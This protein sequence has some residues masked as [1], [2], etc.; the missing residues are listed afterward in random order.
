MQSENTS[1]KR[2][3]WGEKPYYSLD[4]HYRE[5]F[6]QKVYKIALDASMT[7][8][9]RDGTIH[10]RGCIFCSNGG[11][12]EFAMPPQD[13]IS[14]QIDKAIDFLQQHGKKTG[15]QFIAYFQSFSNTYGPVEYLEKIFTQ[16]MEHSSITGLSI[17]T[18]PDCFSPEVYNLLEKLQKQKPLWV[19]LGL[20]TIHES[21]A[22]FIRRGYPLAT[23]DAC[24]ASLRQRKIPAVA[25]II[26]GLPGEGETEV[27][28]TINHLNQL[29]VDGVKIQLL[30]ILKGTDLAEIT[31]PCPVL[32]L[33][34]YT[35][36]LLQ[37]IGHLSPETVIHRLTGDGPRNLLIAPRWSLDKRH[38]LNHIS[39][40]MKEQQIY[41]GKYYDSRDIKII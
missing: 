29:A 18:R 6:G 27:L 16:A 11:S 7:C 36:L 33:E 25:H 32:S 41:Q 5:L 20:Q 39:R 23:F 31:P 17:A 38:V 24:I 13:T 30:H 8:P 15:N 12:G 19:E 34:E 10:D 40:A 4:Y 21:T 28:A 22:R 37:C 9:N 35:N 2:T 26:L 3:R 1:A 14:T